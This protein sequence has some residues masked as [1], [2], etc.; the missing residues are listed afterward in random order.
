MDKDFINST[1]NKMHDFAVKNNLKKEIVMHMPKEIRNSDKWKIRL[2]SNY[3]ES[4][5]KKPIDIILASD[6]FTEREKEVINAIKNGFIALYEILNNE[7]GLQLYNFINEKEYTAYPVKSDKS[8]PD[9]F[10]FFVSILINFE[11]N[12]YILDVVDNFKE[13]IAALL[14]TKELI[15]ENPTFIY[16]D[17]PKKET[18]IKE[19]LDKIYS[20]FMDIFKVDG[21]LI[22]DDMATVIIDLFIE[23]IKNE[24]NDI[25][26]TLVN[27]FQKKSIEE[28][29]SED[30]DIEESNNEIEDTDDDDDDDESEEP[31]PS[32]IFVLR[33]KGV[34]IAKEYSILEEIYESGDIDYIYENTEILNLYFFEDELDYPVEAIL[35]LYEEAEDKEKFL[36]ITRNIIEAVSEEYDFDDFPELKSL[37]LY[38][39][40]ECFKDNYYPNVKTFS[41]YTLHLISRSIN[42]LF[43]E[44][45][46]N[47][48]E[49]AELVEKEDEKSSFK[50]DEDKIPVKIGRNDPC[51]CGS[52]KKYKKCCLE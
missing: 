47:F 4:S 20:E 15:L 41:L 44:Y 5:D 14:L 52:G 26:D 18:E 3:I 27:I 39:I 31:E 46:E 43:E 7:H 6:A 2:Y 34:Y 50:Y 45:E 22:N 37:D 23:V 24:N 42:E 32:C 33:D 48:E 38:E 10:K 8:K 29:S 35:R 49:L 28:S 11:N 51:Y 25:K 16:K 17:N 36:D 12:N 13:R 40:L 30:Q 1:L 21:F 9:K 19:L